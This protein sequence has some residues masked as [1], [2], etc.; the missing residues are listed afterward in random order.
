MGDDIWKS[1]DNMAGVEAIGS[2]P[3][4]TADECLP[5]GTDDNSYSQIKVSN[6]RPL[7]GVD[8]VLPIDGEDSD[9]FGAPPTGNGKAKLVNGL[10]AIDGSV[11]SFYDLSYRIE[12]RS[13]SRGC[14]CRKESQ[15]ILKNVRYVFHDLHFCCNGGLSITHVY[16]SAGRARISLL[17]TIILQYYSFR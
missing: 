14:S 12:V 2:G 6:G 9:W 10:N 1:D 5:P 17:P 4:D 3:V 8:V 16:H 13:Q 7:D 11:I 15:Y